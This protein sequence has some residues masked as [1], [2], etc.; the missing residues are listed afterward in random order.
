MAS[1]ARKVCSEAYQAVGFMADQLGYGTMVKGDPRAV[2]ITKLLD[3]LCAAAAGVPIP[4]A[5]LL[6]FGW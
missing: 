1:D 4:H 5:D 6:P 2:Q 3:N